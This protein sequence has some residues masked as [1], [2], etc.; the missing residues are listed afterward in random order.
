MG[1][2]QSQKP[3]LVCLRSSNS[4]S[5]TLAEL[6][7]PPCF[8]FVLVSL[9]NEGEVLKQLLIA[10]MMVMILTCKG[11]FLTNCKANTSVAVLQYLRNTRHELFPKLLPYFTYL[12]TFVLLTKQPLW[13]KKPLRFFFVALALFKK[14]VKYALTSTIMPKVHWD[15]IVVYKVESQ[16]TVAKERVYSK[17]MFFGL[18][19]HWNVLYLQHF[20]SILV[21]TACVFYSQRCTSKSFIWKTHHIEVKFLQNLG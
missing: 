20:I 21:M 14:P 3:Q 11:Q 8:G 9:L 18:S 6:L 10:L 13:K 12:I 2:S 19:E 5:P 17:F 16:H 7:S 4:L 1:F 15:A